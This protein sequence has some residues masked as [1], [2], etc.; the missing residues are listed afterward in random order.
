MNDEF[1]EYL[2]KRYEELE[3]KMRKLQKEIMEAKKGV[4]LNP[5]STYQSI[6]KDKNFANLNYLN[7]KYDNYCARQLEIGKI[8]DEIYSDF[9]MLEWIKNKRF[10]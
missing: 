6:M 2:L 5:Y 10:I 1:L 7:D 3:N 9:D 8:I 4:T